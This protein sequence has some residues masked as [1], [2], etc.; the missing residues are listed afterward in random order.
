MPRH[1]VVV[2]MAALRNTTYSP[3]FAERKTKNVCHFP[4]A[5]AGL[6]DAKYSAPS[7]SA[8]LPLSFTFFCEI[9]SNHAWPLPL[10][11]TQSVVEDRHR[12]NVSGGNSAPTTW[13]NYSVSGDTFK[14]R[15]ARSYSL[16]SAGPHLLSLPNLR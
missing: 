11:T 12:K 7:T 2:S 9:I 5:N 15:S 13:R 1:D 14:A 10:R 3:H 16:S 8:L 6:S 4:K